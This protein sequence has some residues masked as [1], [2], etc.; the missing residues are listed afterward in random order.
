MEEKLTRFTHGV[1]KWIVYVLLV[2]M[3]VVVAFA[4]IA[5]VVELV[6]S[7]I[8]PPYIDFL[9]GGEMFA[10][11]GA[12]LMVLIGLELVGVVR[13][14]L[15]ESYI[16]VEFVLMVALI[17]V[18]KKVIVLDYK[19]DPLMVIAI[20]ALVLALSTGFFLLRRSTNS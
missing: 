5:L 20:A 18:A 10:V 1:E 4:A 8:D 9:D 12:F 14:Y 7:L 2:L 13:T 3:L 19:S 15:E 11:F 6:V 17:A 16:R